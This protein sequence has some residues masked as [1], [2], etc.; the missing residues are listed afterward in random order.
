LDALSQN[1]RGARQSGLNRAITELR[2]SA[3]PWDVRLAVYVDR[4]KERLMV[5]PEP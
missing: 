2:A 1:G 5:P 4:E 3:S